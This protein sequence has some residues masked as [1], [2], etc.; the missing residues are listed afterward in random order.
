VNAQAAGLIL[1]SLIKKNAKNLDKIKLLP[2]GHRTP[3]YF[4]GQPS[5]AETNL[6]EQQTFIKIDLSQKS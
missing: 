4:V 2:T 5:C 1:F 6:T 3:R